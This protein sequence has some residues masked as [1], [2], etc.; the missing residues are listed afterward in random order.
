MTKLH[1]FIIISY[2]LI[3]N[4]GD[5]TATDKGV[6]TIYDRLKDIATRRE[7]DPTNREFFL[8]KLINGMTYILSEMQVEIF[9]ECVDESFLVEIS[10]IL[11]LIFFVMVV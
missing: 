8:L 3:L 7:L 4:L 9:L 2:D 10:K 1:L 11:R 5:L 6:V